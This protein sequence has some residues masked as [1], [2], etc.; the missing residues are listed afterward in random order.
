M[1]SLF[2][3]LFLI[4]LHFSYSQKFTYIIYHGDILVKIGKT[5]VKDVL[6]NCDFR[7][8]S[9]VLY[10]RYKFDLDSGFIDISQYPY[11]TTGKWLLFSTVCKY[12]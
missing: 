8:D 5:D 7:N 12:S 11:T 10:M 1:K 3:L 9:I 6:E 2:T 4:F